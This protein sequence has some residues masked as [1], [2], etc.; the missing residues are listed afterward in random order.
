M[1]KLIGKPEHVPTVGVTDIVAITSLFVTF[2]VVKFGKELAPVA[3]NPI[4][5]LSFDHTYVMLEKVLV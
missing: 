3:A 1:V 5:V 2:N 4:V